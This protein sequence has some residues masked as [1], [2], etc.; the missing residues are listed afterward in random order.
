MDN[1]CPICSDQSKSDGVISS[2]IDCFLSGGDH[3][4]RYEYGVQRTVFL[5]KADGGTCTLVSFSSELANSPEEVIHRAIDFL[6]KGF[7]DYDVNKNN[8]EDFALCCKT[9]LQVIP[10]VSVGQ[11]WPEQV[12]HRAI[13]FL[14]KGFGDYAYDAIENNSEGFA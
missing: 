5:A 2:C 8:S 10:A 4:Y 9:G 14:L 12:I 1:P 11:S 7:G 13:G 6:R 3:L